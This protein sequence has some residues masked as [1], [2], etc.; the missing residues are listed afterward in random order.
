MSDCENDTCS[1]R[2]IMTNLTFVDTGRY[3]CSYKS[4]PELLDSLFV[5]VNDPD[6][7][8]VPYENMDEVLMMP[9]MQLEPTTIP[10]KCD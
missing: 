7:L 1:S 9:V 4:R 10:C 8:I 3:V 2:L 5:F 6:N